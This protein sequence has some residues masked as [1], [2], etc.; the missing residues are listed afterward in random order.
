MICAFTALCHFR[1]CHASILVSYLC[2]CL[3]IIFLRDF[4][5][6]FYKAHLPFLESDDCRRLWEI[7]QMVLVFPLQSGSL[8]ELFHRRSLDKERMFPVCTV[9]T[10]GIGGLF[11]SLRTHTHIHKTI[12]NKTA[13]EP[14]ESK[15]AFLMR[16]GEENSSA[17]LV[18][19]LHCPHRPRQ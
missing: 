12:K 7:L 18:H 14:W 1:S 4:L 10:Y 11:Y 19:V 9:V 16:R 3:F 6:G 13:L 2:A 5:I 15:G 17:H 8:E